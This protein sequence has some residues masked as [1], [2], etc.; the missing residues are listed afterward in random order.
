MA[1]MPTVSLGDAMLMNRDSNNQWGNMWNNPF[2]YLIWLAMFGN[3]GFG[4]WGGNNA[5]ASN[6]Q[7]AIYASN[8][9]QTLMSQIRGIAN[10][11]SEG[12]SSV[13]YAIGNAI[14]NGF[15]NTNAA[16]NGGFNAV[17][18]NL[19]ENKFAAQQGFC[20]VSQAICESNYKNAQ[21]TGAIITALHNEGE[22]TRALINA[23]TT[24]DLRDKLAA[25]GQAL[26]DAKFALSQEAQTNYLISQLKTTT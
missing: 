17:N 13:N 15:A 18:T 16:M 9:Q 11:V 25:Q 2:M 3:G 5:Q 24:Q 4:G 1:D 8:D 26:Q 21:N 6:L 14:N 10:G 20:G 7:N 23:N 22:Q 12:F 19:M